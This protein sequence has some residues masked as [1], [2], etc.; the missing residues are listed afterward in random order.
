M[1]QTV[2]KGCKKSH[3]FRFSYFV[4]RISYFFLAFLQPFHQIIDQ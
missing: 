4:F 3:F 1:S 2:F